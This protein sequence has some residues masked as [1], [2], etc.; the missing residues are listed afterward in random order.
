MTT[1]VH[2]E[3][4][5]QQSS[6]GQE[7]FDISELR[8]MVMSKLTLS[9]TC[10]IRL[11]SVNKALWEYSQSFRCVHRLSGCER[12]VGKMVVDGVLRCSKCHVLIACN[13]CSR[14]LTKSSYDYWVSYGYLAMWRIKPEAMPAWRR[15]L[16]EA[17]ARPGG[18]LGTEFP[19]SIY[20]GVPGECYW[21]DHDKGVYT[22]VSGHWGDDM[23]FES[24]TDEEL[25]IA[26]IK[27]MINHPKEFVE[28]LGITIV[29]YL[30]D[31]LRHCT[32][33]LAVVE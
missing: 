25:F 5:S 21:V 7:V 1:G 9:P 33:C 24:M 31:N 14:K 20:W 3:V 28:S 23:S 18:F 11:G 19:P 32:D 29:D 22:F 13:S 16:G 2:M 15:M 26:F 17:D 12:V 27:G 30:N 10:F 4:S 8:E 6:P